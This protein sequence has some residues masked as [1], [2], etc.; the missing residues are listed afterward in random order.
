MLGSQKNSVMKKLGRSAVL[1]IGTCSALFLNGREIR[2]PLPIYYTPY[3]YPL[4]WKDRKGDDW[5]WNVD[6]TGAGFY[7]S[8]DA[9]FDE[10]D[11]RCTVPYSTLV[12]GKAD[13]TISESFPGGT[14]GVAQ[15]SNPLA[16]VLEITSRYDYAESGAMFGLHVGTSFCEGKYHTGFRAKLP[17]R[18][19]SVNEVCFEDVTSTGT[20]GP[21]DS[22]YSVYRTRVQSDPPDDPTVVFA[23]RLDFLTQLNLI[24]YG[25][26]GTKVPM[27]IYSDPNNS[28]HISIAGQDVTNDPVLADNTG[29]PPIAVIY[30]TNGAVPVT[31]QWADLPSNGNNALAANGAGF[32][33]NERGYFDQDTNYTSLGASTS[34]QSHLYVVPNLQEIGGST[35]LAPEANAIYNA[36]A[37][38][39]SDLAFD[40]NVDDFLAENGINFCDRR[41][42]GIGDL[43]LEWY[44]NGMWCEDSLLAE[45]KFAVRAPTGD[46]LCSCLTPLKQPTGNN[47]HTEIWLGGVLG[48]EICSKV[49]AHFD[50]YYAFALSHCESVAA[51][52]TGATIKNLGPCVTADISWQYFQGNF[53]LTFLA[54]ECTGFAV[55]YQPYW[56]K[57]DKVCLNQSTATDLAGTPDQPLDASNLQALTRVVAQRVSA[58]FFM[59]TALCDITAGWGTI[60]AGSNATRDTDWYLMFKISF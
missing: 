31:E 19:I 27:V 36:I 7:R 4:Q 16:A 17:Y 23:I 47:G 25:V 40:T 24:D 52:F 13:F 18:D 43:L 60:V 34:N 53:A 20:G 48:Y 14:L 5:C 42:K 6:V 59:R 44:I 33:N 45:F 29:T 30:S 41:T 56:K 26:G 49:M 38:A 2:T 54:D 32:A 11:S 3:H 15:V 35:S 57:C 51:P 39:V 10:C 46:K 9:A 1:L 8:T 22:I 58:E 12:F 28:N 50:G 55:G 37:T 21:A